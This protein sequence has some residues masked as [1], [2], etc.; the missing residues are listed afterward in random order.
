M[1]VSLVGK[2]VLADLFPNL[3]LMCKLVLP[4]LDILLD[5]LLKIEGGFKLVLKGL[6]PL[7]FSV[8]LEFSAALKAMGNLSI[9][10]SNPLANAMLALTAMA[11][12]M[13]SLKASLAL[14]MPTISLQLGLQLSAI[15][16]VIAAASAKMAAI[17]LVIDLMGSLLA[18]ILDI[19]LGIGKIKLPILQL[20]TALNVPGELYLYSG[21]DLYSVLKPVLGPAP[22]PLTD[23]TNVNALVILAASS[24]PAV[25]PSLS[26]IMKTSK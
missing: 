15:A 13:V 26:L 22:H 5:L 12:A 23:S 4:N 9:A 25:W 19:K 17:Q 10:I 11:N 14:G 20:S 16:S 24:T 7:K 3:D 21:A 8:S 2:L 6:F 18:P 1:S